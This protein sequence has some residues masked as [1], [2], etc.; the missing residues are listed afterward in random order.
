[1]VSGNIDD[2]VLRPKI[3]KPMTAITTPTM[4]SIIRGKAIKMVKWLDA[5]PFNKIT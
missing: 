4:T 2:A 1:M 5:S 3:N